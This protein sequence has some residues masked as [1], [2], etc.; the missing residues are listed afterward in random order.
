MRDHLCALCGESFFRIDCINRRG[1]NMMTGMIRILFLIALLPFGAL[2]AVEAED[3]TYEQL[4]DSSYTDHV[5]HFQKL[6]RYAKVRSLLEFGVGYGTKY[7]LDNCK[8]V[9]SCEILF[10]KQKADWFEQTKFLFRGYKNWTPLLKRVSKSF[11][12]ADKIARQEQKNPAL[13]DAAYLTELK[14]IC[15]DLF[16]KNSYD[17]AFVDPGFHMRGDLVNE[18]FDRAAIIVAHDTNAP[19]EVYGWDRVETPVH[20]QKIV[21][22]EGSGVTFWIRKDKAELISALEQ[23][24]GKITSDLQKK[25]RHYRNSLDE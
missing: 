22:K 18:L 14:K 5:Q 11:K 12:S 25:S 13:Q 2:A 6:F 15:D 23:Y 8:E 21:F 10:P 20:Y 4:V 1:S 3:L 17:V 19:F 16:R 9:T 24:A 7:F